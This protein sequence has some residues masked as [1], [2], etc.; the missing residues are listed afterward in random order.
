MLDAYGCGGAGFLGNGQWDGLSS[1]SGL[2][3]AL[4]LWPGMAAGRIAASGRGEARDVSCSGK[5][6]GPYRAGVYGV[7]A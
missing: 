2:S 4:G 1:G 7:P 5:P 6:G 3:V